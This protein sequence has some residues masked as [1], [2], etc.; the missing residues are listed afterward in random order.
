[1][2]YSLQ[3][4]GRGASEDGAVSDGRVAEGPVTTKVVNDP[5]SA[6]CISAP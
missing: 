6:V 5:F 2:S 1:M 4:G 3:V